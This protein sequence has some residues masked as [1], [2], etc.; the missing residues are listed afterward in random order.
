MQLGTNINNKKSKK[1]KPYINL[2]L[3]NTSTSN[4]VEN[5]KTEATNDT[6]LATV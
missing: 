6:Y 1:L 4:K 3:A 5:I 2:T